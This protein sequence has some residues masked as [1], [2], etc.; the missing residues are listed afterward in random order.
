LTAAVLLVSQGGAVAEPKPTIAQAKA[1]LKQLENKADVAVDRYNAANERWKKAKQKYDALN[2]TYSRQQSRVESLRAGIVNLAV[3]S[4]QGADTTV[5][6]PSM[7]SATDPHMVLNGLAALNQIS[8]ERAGAVGGYEVALRDLKGQWGKAKAAL[9]DADSQRDDFRKEKTQVDRLVGEQE[10]L[11]RRLGAFQTGNT[12]SKGVK[13]TGSASGNA[14]TALQFALAQ[15]GKPYRYGGSGP[16]SWDCSGLTQ[17]SWHSGGVSMP[18]TAAQQWAWGAS[19][20]VSISSLQPGD[21]VFSSGLGHVGMF[22]GNGKMVHAPQTGDV[23]KIVT[24]GSYGLGRFI[25][26]VRP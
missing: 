1:K 25:G 19:R 7:A 22:I 10:R 17:A 8:A 21:L 3:S 16:G 6:F 18:R 9:G 24:L 23:V 14:R 12:N 26:A 2:T 5:G 15:V 20:R 13:Y 4:Y 11:L